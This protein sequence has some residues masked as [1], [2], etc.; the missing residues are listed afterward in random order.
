MSPSPSVATFGSLPLV[1]D[2]VVVGRRITSL[3]NVNEFF[4]FG[5]LFLGSWYGIPK[6]VAERF[7]PAG[8]FQLDCNRG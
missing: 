7:L 3:E 5:A 8:A 2:E 4:P 1:S 6:S